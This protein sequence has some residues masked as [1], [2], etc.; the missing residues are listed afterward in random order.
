MINLSQNFVRKFIYLVISFYKTN[1]KIASFRVFHN[2]NSLIIKTLDP[3]KAHGFY[4]ISSKNYTN[5]W[6]I[7]CFAVQTNILRNIEREK[8]KFPD[9]WKIANIAPVHKK[10]EKNLL[11]KYR[12]M[13]SSHFQQNICKVVYG[14]LFNHFVS[15]KLLILS[16]SGFLPGNSCIAQLLSVIHEIHINFDSNHSV[17]VRRCLFR[18]F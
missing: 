16:Q 13:S 4:N 8:K 5:F 1:A 12:P 6:W 18:H 17:D 15:N 3:R 7:Y 10:D 9:I 2:D 14:F 11:K